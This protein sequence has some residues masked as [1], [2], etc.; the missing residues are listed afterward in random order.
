MASSEDW[1]THGP[2]IVNDVTEAMAQLEKHGACIIARAIGSDLLAELRTALYRAAETDRRYG[3]KQDY[4]FGSDDSVNQRVWNLPSHDPVFCELVEHPMAIDIVHRTL[5]WPASLSSMSANITNGGGVSGQLHTDQ[6]YLPEPLASAWV[7]N[8][9]W[10]LDDFRYDNGATLISPGSHK[11]GGRELPRIA[12][13]QMIPIVAPAGSL[14][15]MDGRLWHTNGVNTCGTSRAAAFAVYTLPW[16]MPQENWSRSINPS[17]R[18]FGSDTLQT[19]FGFRP[20][21]LG[22]MNGWDRVQS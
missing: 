19:L 11:F 14:I 10:C 3:L 16:L 12:I 22:R 2:E 15:V 17:I 18:Q 1:L 20:T 8:F 21:V 9:A 5:G 13:D 4:Q 7:Y 6:I